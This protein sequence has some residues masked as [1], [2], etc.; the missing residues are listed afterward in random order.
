[1][2]KEFSRVSLKDMILVADYLASLAEQHKVF[3]FYGPMGAGKTTLIGKT[4]RILLGQELD[5]TSP[6]FALVNVYESKNPVYHFDCY[7]IEKPE[8]ALNAGIEE[9]LYSNAICLVEWP[10]KIESILPQNVIT[11]TLSTPDDESNRHIEINI[12]DHD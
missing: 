8:D 6:T 9:M 11:V 3:A 7:R 1:M 5:V 4:I 12:P 10:E 2:K